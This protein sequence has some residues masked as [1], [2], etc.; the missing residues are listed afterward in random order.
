MLLGVRRKRVSALLG[1]PGWHFGG[2]WPVRWLLRLRR[3]SRGGGTQYGYEASRG[4]WCALPNGNDSHYAGHDADLSRRHYIIGTDPP[5]CTRGGAPA[6]GVQRVCRP[7]L[8]FEM[9][10]SAPRCARH[11]VVSASAHTRGDDIVMVIGASGRRQRA[12]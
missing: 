11:S 6:V 4:G 7:P 10:I 8:I 5:R 3:R 12:C 9:L 2:F 1:A